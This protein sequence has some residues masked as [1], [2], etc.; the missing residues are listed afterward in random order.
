MGS[1]VPC[2]EAPLRSAE[3]VS[4]DG[5]P[6]LARSRTAQRNVPRRRRWRALSKKPRFLLSARGRG[7]EPDPSLQNAWW[8]GARSLVLLRVR[9][10]VID[11]IDDGLVGQIDTAALGGHET[12]LALISL[13]RMLV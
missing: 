11:G 2:C 12:C 8:H 13:D 10:H 6:G 3:R 5:H 1:A 7:K 4:M 9:D